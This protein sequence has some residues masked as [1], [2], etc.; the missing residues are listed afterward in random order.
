MTSLFD[1][2]TLS[3]GPAWRNRFML[4]PLTNLQS[5]PDGRLSDDEFEWLTYRA[6]GGF[7]LVMTCASH[8]QR[9]GQGFPGQLGVFSDDHLPGLTRLAAAI[10]A[11]GAVS[12]VQLHHAGVRSPKDLVGEDPVGP[13]DFAETGARALSEAEVEALRDDFIAAAV[14]AQSAGFDGVELHGAHGYILCAFLSPE[15]NQR[16]D[17]YGGSAANRARLLEEI[18]AGVRANTRPDF[19]L[20][21]RLSPERFGLKFAEQRDLAGRLL[22]GGDLDY[23]DMSLWDA[24]KAPVETE[25]AGRPLIDWFAELP[26]GATRIGAAGKL[27]SGADCRCVLEHGM[28]FP[29]LGRAA[30]LHHDFARRVEADPDF[31]AASLPVSREHLRRERLGE[32]FLGYMAGWKGFVA[33]DEAVEAA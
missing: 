10:K 24:F 31:R 17:R 5:H 18:I 32:A 20:G 33:E 27:M 28:D 16:A 25:F 13:S 21:V 12:S 1:P 23:L 29:V 2:L 22:T 3:R 19:Q 4:A 11:G 14:R 8:V 9:I 7:G 15:L 6:V 26:R 30:I